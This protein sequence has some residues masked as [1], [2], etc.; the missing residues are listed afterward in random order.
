MFSWKGS[1]AG[2]WT[3]GGGGI[4]EERVFRMLKDKIQGIEIQESRK[5]KNS[6]V[7]QYRVVI[8]KETN[9]ALEEMVKRASEGFD[10]GEIAKSD[11]VNLVVVNYVKSFSESDIKALR[12]LHFNERRMLKALLRKGGGEG[13]LPEEI[14]RAVREYCGMVEPGKRRASRSQA[15]PPVERNSD[16]SSAP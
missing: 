12:N 6:D 13:E 3:R 10:G 7:D 9:D 5:S 11:V 4:Q 2:D 8:S 15:E 14:K 16:N 1:A